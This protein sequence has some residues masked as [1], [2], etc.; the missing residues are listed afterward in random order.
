MANNPESGGIIDCPEIKKFIDN[1]LWP[2]AKD[3]AGGDIR[4]YN[5]PTLS[6]QKRTTSPDLMFAESCVA[7]SVYKNEAY[8]DLDDVSFSFTRVGLLTNIWMKAACRAI[9]SP[10]MGKPLSDEFAGRRYDGNDVVNIDFKNMLW[11]GK[12]P[13]LTAVVEYTSL[14][15]DSY[16]LITSRKYDFIKLLDG[17]PIGSFNTNP[18][19]SEELLNHDDDL[20]S[21]IFEM[22]IVHESYWDDR[23]MRLAKYVLDSL[24]L[25]SP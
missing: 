17:Q 15:I 2:A 10:L 12:M 11:A 4:K 18:V 9:N 7:F 23:D 21:T 8:G 20:D 14:D 13:P 22:D 19:F 5:T 16:E 1:Q 6:L 25:Y 3:L 24:G